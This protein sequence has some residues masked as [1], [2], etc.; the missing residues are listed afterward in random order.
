MYT[1]CS[2]IK[3]KTLKDYE[4]IQHI[5]VVSD[6]AFNMNIENNYEQL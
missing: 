2:F 3:Y 5:S 6:P 1:N 4:S